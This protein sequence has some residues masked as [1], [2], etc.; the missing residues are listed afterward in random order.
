MVRTLSVFRNRFPVGRNVLVGFLGTLLI[1]TAGAATAQPGTTKIIDPATGRPVAEAAPETV[2][3]A[4]PETAPETVSDAAPIE[5]DTVK[6]PPATAVLLSENERQ[7]LLGLD[8]T[9]NTSD[10]AHSFSVE[11]H[12][13]LPFTTTEVLPKAPSEAAAEEQT[14]TES[15]AVVEEQPVPEE[16]SATE[17]QPTAE[18]Q[19]ATEAQPTTESEAVAEAQPVPEAEAV[20]EAQPVPEAESEAADLAPVLLPK[21][22]STTNATAEAVA[23]AP[24]V[25]PKALTPEENALEWAVVGWRSR[26]EK[27]RA[28]RALAEARGGKA[29]ATKASAEASAA[30]AATGQNTKEPLDSE[31]QIRLAR[32]DS[33]APNDAQNTQNAQSAPSSPNAP[34][35]TTFDRQSFLTAAPGSLLSTG[36][37][38]ASDAPSAPSQPTAN[39]LP[40]GS[41]PLP[42]GVSVAPTDLVARSALT[43]LPTGEGFMATVGANVQGKLIELGVP[44]LDAEGNPALDEKGRPILLPLRRGMKVQKG[45]VL[46]RQFNR[47]FLARK[48]AA[49]RQL[50]VAE[51]ESTNELEV[52]VAAA[53]TRLAKASY[54]RAA[55]ANEQ[56]P[57]ASSPEELDEKRYDWERSF[58]SWEKSKH[59]LGI[60]VDQVEVSKAELMITEAQ[61][62]E[63]ELVSPIDGQINEIMRNEGEWLREGDP[64]F[65]VIRLDKI[66][67]KA[68]FNAMVVS[69][70]MV[71][72]K[73][74]TVYATKPGVPMQTFEGTITYASPLIENKTLTAF[75]E[76]TNSQDASGSWLLNPGV[77]VSLVVHP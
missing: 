39:E 7:R 5:S 20:A 23:E 73:N 25:A 53:A 14:T 26:V 47:E 75:A 46:G 43:E 67:V 3:N 12:Q 51:K 49:E 19:S 72:G 45:Q 1:F 40:G 17:E 34:E 27:N 30:T 61:L 22:E 77:V 29:T 76:V 10:A 70:E 44:Q 63:R 6:E 69:P 54:D 60:K 68:S 38:P 57:G 41:A 52:E 48:T 56:M 59:D 4:A 32:P 58:K 35:E 15:E 33:P 9:I 65:Q 16:Q 74:V 62:E 24:S 31:T 21:A 2:S 28:V 71:Q 13:E 42:T 18:E 66:Q 11:A 55:A 36:S 64:V 50:V 8:S 37:A